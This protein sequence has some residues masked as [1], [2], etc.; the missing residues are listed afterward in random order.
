MALEKEAL[1][2][3]I[4]DDLAARNRNWDKIEAHM[5]D[6]AAHLAESSSKHITESGSNENGNYIRFD[7]GTQICWK[8][9]MISSENLLAGSHEFTWVFPVAFS[10]TYNYCSLNIG[11][12]GE[13]YF[14]R[15]DKVLLRR[16]SGSPDRT[17]CVGYVR[18]HS[19]MGASTT[20]RWL[21]IGRWK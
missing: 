21:A 1:T 9:E 11:V 17:S 13:T 20:F 19:D 6:Y 4:E 14:P 7:D 2:H 15:V 3:K 5:A 8:A 10:E 12:V 18:L 16:V